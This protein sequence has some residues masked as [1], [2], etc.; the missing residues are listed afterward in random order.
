MA[1]SATVSLEISKVTISHVFGVSRAAV[2]QSCS[3]RS[4]EDDVIM[5]VYKYITQRAPNKNVCVHVAQSISLELLQILRQ[6]AERRERKQK[7]AGRPMKKVNFRAFKSLIR[8]VVAELTAEKAVV[9]DEYFNP[10]TWQPFGPKISRRQTPEIPD[11]GGKVI[12]NEHW[13]NPRLI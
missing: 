2:T 9:T 10:D 3:R 8:A 13:I 12:P 1:I 6:T 11:I 5:R 4:V 7:N